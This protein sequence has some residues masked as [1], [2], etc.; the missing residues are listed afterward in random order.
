M[1][2]TDEN[3]NLSQLIMIGLGVVQIVSTYAGGWLMDKFPKKT[4]LIGGE[5]AMAV[6]LFCIFMSSSEGVI[7]LLVFIHTIAYSFSIGQL[8][9]YY[10]VKMLPST[11]V[12]IL[13]NWFFTFI[14]AL[15]AEFMM[16]G[17]GIGN[18][19]LLFFVLLSLCLVVLVKGIPEEKSMSSSIQEPLKIKLK[20]EEL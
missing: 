15:T 10:P 20:P 5:G 7:I 17:L 8:L 3:N 14:V 19:C 18:M 9:M 11:G 13:V 12:V 4:F 2:V 16:K 6:C 1:R